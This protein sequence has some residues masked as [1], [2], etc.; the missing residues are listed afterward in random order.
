MAKVNFTAGRVEGFKCED[1][2]SQAFLWC[3]T[4][5]G[6]AVRATPGSKKN[7]YIFQSRVEGKPVRLTI[8]D[9]KTWGIDQAQAEARRLQ[10]QIDHGLSLIHIS[11][12]TRPY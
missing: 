5:P 4:V 6:L 1:G 10:I 9:C 8:G 11:E 12:P 3:A 2:K 7:K